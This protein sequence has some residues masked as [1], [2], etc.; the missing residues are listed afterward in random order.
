MDKYVYL[1]RFSPL[2]R[3]HQQVINKL[4]SDYGIKKLIIMIGSSNAINEKT[5]YTF[6]FRKKIIRATYPKIKILP[7][8]DFNHDAK[9]LKYIKQLESKLNSRFI[10]FGGSKTDLQL[11]STV[12]DTK[13]LVD[14]FEEGENIS[15][16]LV[17][18]ALK[19]NNI[20]YLKKSLDPITFNLLLTKMNYF[21]YILRTSKNT[22]YTGQTSNLDRRIREHK[23][24]SVKSAKYLKYFDSFELV[25]SEVHLSKSSALKR[26]IELKKWPKSKKE[27][28]INNAFNNPHNIRTS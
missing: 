28:M 26:E 1:G 12:F 8:P 20:K 5:P 19:D 27:A 24:K 21:V 4:I 9:W 17:R 16:T 25:Y 23:L 7:I 15:G 6:S 11:L 10:F 3:G 22:L 13:V 14:R 18:Q 2:H